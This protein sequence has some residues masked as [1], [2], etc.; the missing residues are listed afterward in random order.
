VR[1]VADV[2]EVIIYFLI[3]PRNC[4]IFTPA[5]KFKDKFT[6]DSFWRCNPMRYTMK[7]DTKNKIQEY[8]GILLKISKELEKRLN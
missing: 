6:S 5:I 3:M 1:A 2:D 4:N 8:R 7:L